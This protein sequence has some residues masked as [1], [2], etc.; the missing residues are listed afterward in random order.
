MSNKLQTK[1]LDKLPT[2]TLDTVAVGDSCTIQYCSLPHTL[3]LRLEEMGL[4]VGAEVTILKAAPL[5]D[6]L[7]IRVRGYTLCIRKDLAQHYRVRKIAT[8]R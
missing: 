3:K 8:P 1:S 2:T 7:E 5:G 4:T 6:P